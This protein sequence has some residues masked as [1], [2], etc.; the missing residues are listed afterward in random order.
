MIHAAENERHNQISKRNS[1]PPTPE[2]DNLLS[3]K[4]QLDFR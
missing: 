1:M 3:K 4:E 2:K